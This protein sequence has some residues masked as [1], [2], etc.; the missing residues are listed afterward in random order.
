MK[1]ERELSFIKRSDFGLITD[2][3]RSNYKIN[4]ELPDQLLINRLNNKKYK[5]E[6]EENILQKHLTTVDY[7][8][9]EFEFKKTKMNL[10]IIWMINSINIE[11]VSENNL[12]EFINEIKDKYNNY[13]QHSI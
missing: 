5:S 11:S 7:K 4:Y 6:E 12:I 1:F 13:A 2:L 9:I 10:N 3:I 8:V